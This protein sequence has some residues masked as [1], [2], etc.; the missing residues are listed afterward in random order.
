MKQLL[1]AFAV[2]LALPLSCSDEPEGPC[3]HHRDY[4]TCG[5]PLD[6]TATYPTYSEELATLFPSAC[7]YGRV[8]RG[9]CSDGKVFLAWDAGLGS[10]VSYYRGELFVGRVETTDVVNCYSLCP[11]ASFVGTLETVRCDSPQMEMMCQPDSL[12][13]GS[14]PEDAPFG[15]G[16]PGLTCKDLCEPG[17]LPGE[18]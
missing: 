4:S 3:P 17:K 10:G 5:S 1:R 9:T 8:S 6:P 18:P 12:E 14:I 7:E 13:K 16:T 15:A 2:A 11:L